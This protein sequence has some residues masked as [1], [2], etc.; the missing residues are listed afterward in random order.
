MGYLKKLSCQLSGR[1][2]DQV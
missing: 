2:V 1:S